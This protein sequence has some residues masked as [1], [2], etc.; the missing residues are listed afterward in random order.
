[1]SN[2]R[3]VR[4]PKQ[5]VLRK[6]YLTHIHGIYIYMDGLTWTQLIMHVQATLPHDIG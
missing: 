4:Y 6:A 5:L 1:M 3:M 2:W